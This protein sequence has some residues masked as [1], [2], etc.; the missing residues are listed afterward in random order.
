MPPFTRM[1]RP[2]FRHCR[3]ARK[4]PCAFLPRSVGIAVP[5]CSRLGLGLSGGQCR[6][7]RA[8]VTA[9]LATTAQESGSLLLSVMGMLVPVVA[10]PDRACSALPPSRLPRL[11]APA[12]AGASAG[13]LRTAS[14]PCGR[15]AVGRLPAVCWCDNKSGVGQAL[16]GEAV[17]S[18]HYLGEHLGQLRLQGEWVC[19]VD[20]VSPV[21]CWLLHHD[22]Q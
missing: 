15:R 18:R 8:T 7:S 2:I 11:V 21:A 6:R 5:V 9:T 20:V 14:L 13:P 10:G 1:S 17:A 3:Q 22:E 16:K 4:R 12:W 19:P